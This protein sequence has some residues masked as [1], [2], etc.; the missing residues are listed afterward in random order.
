LKYQYETLK[1]V[2]DVV[3]RDTMQVGDQKLP[4]R[5]KEKRGF[6]ETAKLWVGWDLGINIKRS[7]TKMTA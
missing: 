4:E 7:M 1:Q 5:A 3:M 6:S 2:D